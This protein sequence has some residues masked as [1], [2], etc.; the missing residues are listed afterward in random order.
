MAEALSQPALL[1]AL[2]KDFGVFARHWTGELRKAEAAKMAA[3]PGARASSPPADEA[4]GKEYPVKT[5]GELRHVGALSL[6]V[7]DALT[8]RNL[9]PASAVISV[10]DADVV[11]AMRTGKH[12][13]LPED[14]YARLPEHLTK[15]DAVLLDTTHK[16]GPA[17]LMLYAQPGGNAKL[18]VRI[19]YSTKKDGLLNIVETGKLLDETDSIKSLIGDGHELIDGA[20]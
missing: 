10:R 7:V 13:P 6:K 19:N 12:H 5:T 2:T 17:L 9:P 11:H 3:P 8:L 1:G 15:P 4:A 14:W 20:L 16:E 18:V